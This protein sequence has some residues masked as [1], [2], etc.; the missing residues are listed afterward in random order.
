MTRKYVLWR[1]GVT[2]LS[3]VALGTVG[4]I[5]GQSSCPYA[6]IR[7][8][9]DISVDTHAVCAAAR[10]WAE[11][12]TD[13]FILLT[14]ERPA[15]EDAWSAYLSRAEEVAGIRHPGVTA[16]LQANAIVFEATTTVDDLW[17]YNVA[18][19]EKL[20][21]TPLDNEA[22][23]LRIRETMCDEIAK[24]NA[25]GSLIVALELTHRLYRPTLTPFWN[26]TGSTALALGGIF[27]FLVLLLAFFALRPYLQR[28]RR[29]KLLQEQLDEL[30]TATTNFFDVSD[31][32]LS[33]ESSGD[34]A[35]YQL[36]AAYGGEHRAALQQQ[37]LEWLQCSRDILNE[38]T[39]QRDALS[40]SNSEDKRALE[41]LVREW[42]T[43]YLT[44]IGSEKRLRDLSEAELHRLLDPVLVLERRAA[45]VELIERLSRIHSEITDKPLK[46]ELREAD[47]SEVGAVGLLGYVALIKAEIARL[48]LIWT[49]APQQLEHVRQM[50]TNVVKA[51]PSDFLP[52]PEELFP[53][54]DRQLAAAEEHLES[55]NR[56]STIDVTADVLLALETIKI[57]AEVLKEHHRRQR[58]IDA[59]TLPGYRPENLSEQQDEAEMA[60][61]AAQLALASS[62]YEEARAW[63][64]LVSA[65][66][67]DMLAGVH[68]WMALHAE[69]AKALQTLKE[70]LA[71]IE[72]YRDEEVVA[73][74]EVLLKYGPEN[75][76]QIAARLDAASERLTDL[77]SRVLPELERANTTSSQDFV[78]VEY[79]LAQAVVE[80]TRIEQQLQQVVNYQAETQTAESVIED[81]IRLTEAEL[82]RAVA[83]HDAHENASDSDNRLTVEAAG[84]RLADA[85]RMAGQHNFLAAIEELESARQLLSGVLASANRQTEEINELQE[86]VAQIAR[87][88]AAKVERAETEIRALPHTMVTPQLHQLVKR[89]L[90]ALTKG[91][92]GRMAALGL[93]DQALKNALEAALVV[94]EMADERADTALNT[95][96]HARETYDKL[97]EKAA[98]A[99]RTTQVTIDQAERRVGALNA[100][101]TGAEALKRAHALLPSPIVPEDATKNGLQR[102]YNR[103]TAA[104]RYAKQAEQQAERH[105]EQQQRCQ[106]VEMVATVASAV[107]M[108]A[109]GHWT[110]EQLFDECESMPYVR[111]VLRR[112]S[113]FGDGAP[114]SG[115]SRAY[116]TSRRTT[117]GSLRRNREANASSKRSS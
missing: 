37:V 75:F 16:P 43:L 61:E 92:Q 115:D 41:G 104:R 66:S 19:G 2:L 15:G 11:E 90:S 69:N 18:Y 111:S 74:W 93:E 100:N 14:D 109:A 101:H 20:S 65:E 83:L 27:L 42:E 82:E 50:R 113:A 91:R 86:Q 5:Y 56:L 4:S 8:D 38:V 25:T 117:T 94:F 59:L 29:R 58:E 62:N 33:G 97:Q 55:G 98:V 24:G 9:T 44:F 60:L 26:S 7:L 76:P 85:R 17:G 39:A 64:E 54:V 84:E 110:P 40:H 13:V 52:P 102:I 103:A 105:I 77:R 47:S 46:V 12:G 28:R 114:A 89:A 88:V 96:R 95:V 57:F 108:M 72:S 51:L 21:G 78:G 10:P 34:T 70:E 68:R 80:L 81:A 99:I 63:I 35:F 112:S 116:G 23:L 106:H 79:R 30:R 73:A 36:F 49:E 22:A 67:Q 87:D 71:R 31:Q 45:S 1:V 6:R 3:L 48:Q 107:G 32:L 53:Q